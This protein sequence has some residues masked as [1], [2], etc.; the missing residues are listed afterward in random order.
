MGRHFKS[1]NEETGSAMQLSFEVTPEHA[2][3]MRVIMK[4][5]RVT[6]TSIAQRCLE[7]GLKKVEDAY[8][9]FGEELG[10]E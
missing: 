10:R 5:Y 9:K 2:D 4:K 3:R 1:A 8:Q 6:A 7:L